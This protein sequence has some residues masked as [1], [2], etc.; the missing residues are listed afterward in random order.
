MPILYEDGPYPRGVNQWITRAIAPGKGPDSYGHSFQST[1]IKIT[2]DDPNDQGIRDWNIFTNP[3][4]SYLGGGQWSGGAP[5]QQA[6]KQTSDSWQLDLPPGT[7]YFLI[8][9]SG[10]PN[11]G[12]YTGTIQVGNGPAMPYTGVD[13]NHAV[14]IAVSGIPTPTPG[15]GPTPTPTPTPGPGPYPTPG[16]PMNVPLIV[17]AGVTVAAIAGAAIYLAKRR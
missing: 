3:P 15:P 12:T 14:T 16:A 8:G 17:G 2:G 7:Y 4:G 5:V 13:A 6:F 11:Y 10:G 9:Q 1:T